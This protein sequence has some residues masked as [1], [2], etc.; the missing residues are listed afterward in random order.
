MAVIGQAG[1]SAAT[2]QSIKKGLSPT[3]NNPLGTNLTVKFGI[4]AVPKLPSTY[5]LRI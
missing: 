4:S 2:R 3:Q 1:A 5:S